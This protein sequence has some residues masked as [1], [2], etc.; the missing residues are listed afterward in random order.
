LVRGEKVLMPDLSGRPFLLLA[1][2]GMRAPAEKIYQAWTEEFDRWFAAPGSVAMRAEAGAPFFFE[3]EFEGARHPHYGRF[4]RLEPNRL[5]EMTWVT[6]ATLG[7][8]TVVTVM[9]SAQGSG[10]RL[11]LKHAGFP[12]EGL[13][14]RHEEAWPKV[15]AHMD[16]IYG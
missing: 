9:L 3:T 10:T 16:E 2:R 8:E 13:R 6:G 12:N 1:E 11:Q 4:L 14:Q 5:V 7:M 15:L